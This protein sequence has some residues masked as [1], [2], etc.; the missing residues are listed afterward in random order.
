MSLSYTAVAAKVKA[1]LVRRGR[2][3]NLK[4]YDAS[5]TPDT[6][7]PWRQ[8]AS[9]AATKDY[10]VKGIAF[11][12]DPAASEPDKMVYVPAPAD[13]PDVVLDRHWIVTVGDEVYSVEAAQRIDPSGDPII[14]WVLHCKAW[15]ANGSY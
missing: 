6:T 5:T 14:L 9:F 4:L 10:D 2:T 3:I 13:E 7:M 12:G 15:P 11:D 8:T 1:L